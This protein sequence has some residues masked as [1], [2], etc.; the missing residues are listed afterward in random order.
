[1]TALDPTPLETPCLIIARSDTGH[2]TGE[3]ERVREKFLS[4][5]TNK[6]LLQ[7]NNVA[8]ETN[9][10]FNRTQCA[11]V[12]VSGQSSDTFGTSQGPQAQFLKQRPNIIIMANL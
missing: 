4:F 8:G 3:R 6:N 5:K 7:V 1:M 2:V 9:S 10:Y 12:L 11:E